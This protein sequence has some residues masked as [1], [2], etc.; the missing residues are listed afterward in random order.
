MRFIL[1]HRAVALSVGVDLMST[2]WGWGRGKAST[3]T[4]PA[5]HRRGRIACA[6]MARHVA[7]LS[8]VSLV[9]LRNE[10]SRSPQHGSFV[11]NDRQD[12][13]YGRSW[14]GR[15][16]KSLPTKIHSI[17]NLAY[18]RKCGKLPMLSHLLKHPGIARH[19]LI[20]KN[21]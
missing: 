14:E 15:I 16:S 19:R 5:L 7:L 12:I 10:G 3:S 13:R 20:Y 6:R 2:R 17:L 21:T 9:I 1:T 4:K 18:Y 11:Q 8:Q